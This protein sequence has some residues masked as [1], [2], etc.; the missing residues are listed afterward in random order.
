MLTLLTRRDISHVKN[1][2]ACVT[3]TQFRSELDSVLQRQSLGKQFLTGG[4]PGLLAF[5]P[6]MI[7][8][9]S[10][11]L[12]SG[13]KNCHNSPPP[14]DPKITSYHDIM[15]CFP[16]TSL[17]FCLRRTLTSFSTKTRTET[18]H[19][20]LMQLMCECKDVGEFPSAASLIDICFN[21]LQCLT[22]WA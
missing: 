15:W 17:L 8:C 18:L 13:A 1:V 2:S 11:L 21:N 5:L 14:L 7:H 10:K 19:L 12:L 16:I 22:R 4:L 9:Y 6:E 3:T 20:M